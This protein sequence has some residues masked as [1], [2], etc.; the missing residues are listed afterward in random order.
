MSESLGVEELDLKD[1]SDWASP[2]EELVPEVR[3]HESPYEVTRSVDRAYTCYKQ[4]KGENYC[5]PG[6]W[7][8]SAS[9]INKL[10]L[11]S[12]ASGVALLIPW[13]FRRCDKE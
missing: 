7:N 13:P 6:T 2:M 10:D 1:N 3:N 8:T 4:L 5:I 11:Y 12:V 9:T